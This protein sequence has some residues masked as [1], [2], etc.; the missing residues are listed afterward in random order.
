MPHAF[1]CRCLEQTLTDARH[2]FQRLLDH[3]R[4]VAALAVAIA[5]GGQATYPRSDL[6]QISASA[7][8]NCQAAAAMLTRLIG[9]AG[10]VVDTSV[11]QRLVLVVDDSRDTRD[12]TADA[13]E[14]AGF[15]TITAGNGLD[16]V[17][18]A[19]YARPVV[20][21]MDVTMPVLDGIEATRLLKASAATR[22]VNVIAHTANNEDSSSFARL[23][24]GVLL[25][26]TH[27]DLVIATVQRFARA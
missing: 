25:K 12:M 26:P 21:L 4:R 20:I 11:S 17:I 3:E 24:D 1:D 15:H 27:P 14:S 18:A 9:E 2:L 10:A 19:H 8:D 7:R 6:A 13:L 22:Q 5:A 16:G 23:F